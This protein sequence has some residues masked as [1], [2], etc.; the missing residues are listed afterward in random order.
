MDTSVRWLNDYLAPPATAEEQATLLTLAGFPLEGS[1]AV[2]L[3]SESDVCQDF[4]MTSN[5]GDCVCHV[6]LAREI[7]AISGRTL[8]VPVGEPPFGKR[9]AAESIEVLNEEP[10][11]CPLYTG[12]VIRGV[13]VGPSPQWL[14]DRLRAIGQIPRNNIVD[15]TNFVLFELGQPTHVF[16]LA[17]LRGQKIIIRRAQK[18]ERFLPIGEGESE[19]RLTQKDL[20]IADAERAV[21][22]AGVKGGALTAVRDGST[23]LLLEAATFDRVT[24]RNSSRRHNIVSDSSYRFERGV[25]PGQINA[26]A[27]RL[28]ALILELAGGELEEGVVLDGRPIPAPRTLSMRRSRCWAILGVPVPDEQMLAGLTRLGFEPSLNGDV[29]H[30]RVPIHRLD[31]EREID[32]IEEVGRMH[33]MDSIPVED[34]IPVRVQPLQSTELGRVAVCETLVGAGYVETIT[35]SLI[36]EK[37]AGLFLSED[38]ELLR[39]DEDRA[40]AEPILRPSL[41]A[42][43]ARVRAMNA[44]RGTSPLRLF[45][46]GSTFCRQDGAIAERV[47]L[48]LLADAEDEAQPLRPMRGVIERLAQLLLG[49]EV[50]VGV[51]AVRPKTA[52]WL[53]PAGRVLVNGDPIGHIGLMAET[54][55]RHFDLDVPLVAAELDL[56]Q[57]Y[58]G[59]PP[60]DEVCA[61]PHHPA[62][63]R[64]VSAIVQES[65]AWDAVRQTIESL[66]LDHLESLRFV[67][68][69]RGKQIGPGRKSLTLR[70]RFRAA[71]RTL[72]HDEVDP[73]I[74]AVV[75]AL[76]DRFDAEIRQ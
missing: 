63:A 44:D 34:A 1:E 21:A 42:S 18:D 74:D 25:H 69:F 51:E 38:Q 33:G 55:R 3:E 35:H 60:E 13:R 66:P 58:A 67:T 43:L 52:S 50:T 9:A 62:I 29:V 19:V 59:Y 57:F 4:E 45:E 56:P 22:I 65:I 30:C 71:D 17:T 6:G 28:A 32:L 41:L 31:I 47:R 70:L 39:V 36:G 8:K 23:D 16:D 49:R 61:L 20:V 2:E 7:A 24:V 15:A 14:A 37:A 76:R 72:V 10:D 75:K 12:R 26:A 54:V 64:D 5:R 73:Q 11:L 40:K 53:D 46:G 68:A 48:A 27:N